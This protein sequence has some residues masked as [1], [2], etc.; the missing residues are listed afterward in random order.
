[1]IY[2]DHHATTPCDPRVV[3]SDAALVH[4]RFGNA[5]SV[6]HALGQEAAAAV[7]E[8]RAQVARLIGATAAEIILT[9]GATEINNL[10]I[11]GAARFALSWGMGGGGS[12]PSPPSIMRC[13]T[14]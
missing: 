1:M 5:G 6:E 10:A 4:H 14:A 12:S 8:A 3:P 2:L 13:W 9:S 7:E 11:K